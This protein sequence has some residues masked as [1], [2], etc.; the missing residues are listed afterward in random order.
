M[1]HRTTS[2]KKKIRNIKVKNFYASQGTIINTAKNM[3]HKLG[4]HAYNI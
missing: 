1:W 3:G 2:C 4:T